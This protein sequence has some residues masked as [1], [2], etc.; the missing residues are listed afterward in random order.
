MGRNLFLE[1]TTQPAVGG[2]LTNITVHVITPGIP[3]DY[4]P[5][6]HIGPYANDWQQRPTDRGRLLDKIVCTL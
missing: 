6:D 5:L 4:T 2:K 3:P 1:I